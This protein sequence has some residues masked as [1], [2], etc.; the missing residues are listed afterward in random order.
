LEYADAIKKIDAIL[1]KKDSQDVLQQVVD[2]LKKNF[3]H[4]SWVGLYLVQGEALVL[5][6]WRGRE[7]TEH[8][9]IPIG[10]GIC[11]SAAQNGRTEI[12]DD[13][14]KDARYLSCFLSTRSEIV[15]PIKKGNIVVGE[16]DIDADVPAA[17]TRQDAVFLEKVADMLSKHI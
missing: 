17:F 1:S 15:V 7:A 12:V 14:S 4:Y 2:F 13:V 10:K 8:T 16:I 3:V 6:P 9:K 5:G 11:G